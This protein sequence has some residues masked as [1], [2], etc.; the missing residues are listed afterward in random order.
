MKQYHKDNVGDLCSQESQ[1]PDDRTLRGSERKAARFHFNF[2]TK[3][4]LLEKER[5]SCRENIMKSRVLEQES[6]S[7]PGFD[8]GSNRIHAESRMTQGVPRQT[9]CHNGED[10]L[11]KAVSTAT[12]QAGKAAKEGQ[13]HHLQATFP[14]DDATASQYPSPPLLNNEHKPPSSPSQ[15]RTSLRAQLRSRNG[16]SKE[17]LRVSFSE[18]PSLDFSRGDR[19]TG[20]KLDVLDLDRDPSPNRSNAMRNS[21]KNNQSELHNRDLKLESYDQMYVPCSANYRELLKKLHTERKAVDDLCNYTSWSANEFLNS[22]RSSCGQLLGQHLETDS[23]PSSSLKLTSDAKPKSPFLPLA[24][25][26]STSFGDFLTKH[27]SSPNEAP[28]EN[29]P[30]VSSLASGPRKGQECRSVSPV[31]MDFK[32][33]AS[34]QAPVTPK[35]CFQE[36]GVKY[37]YSERNNLHP[38]AEENISTEKNSPVVTVLRQLLELVDRYWSGSGSLLHNKEFLAVARN[39]LA[40]LTTLTPSHQDGYP[41]GVA[42][43]GQNSAGINYRIQPKPCQQCNR[44]GRPVQKQTEN[45]VPS[46]KDRDGEA[47]PAFHGSPH[48]SSSLSY[49]ELLNRNEVLS[50]QVDVMSLELKQLKKQQETIS[51]LRE[52]QKSLVSTNNF[53]LQQLTRAHSPVSGKGGFLSGKEATADNAPFCE[54]LAHQS[55]LSAFGSNALCVTEQL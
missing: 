38:Q 16:P 50:A 17:R 34:Q 7:M 25:S 35:P 3:E 15:T 12:H 24:H 20:R 43:S 26:V 30:P 48:R 6:F 46:F 53:L 29:S 45:Q 31:R 47:A 19:E 14:L 23:N 9:P 5:S 37:R 1:S 51:L 44:M 18:S 41:A 2:K 54:K 21:R 10:A 32:Q 33:A 13:Q 55:P 39:L 11:M 8:I 4:N 42:T 28:L 40:Q 52:S 49:D 27:G 22:T 36:P